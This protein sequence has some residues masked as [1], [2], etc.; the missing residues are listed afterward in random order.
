M[1][2]YILLFQLS[3]LYYARTVQRV[4][5]GRETNSLRWDPLPF[6]LPCP[7]LANR[8]SPDQEVT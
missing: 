5:A 6:V 7:N 1:D 3:A 4:I 2:C 8:A